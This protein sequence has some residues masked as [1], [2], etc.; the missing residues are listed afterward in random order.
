[1]SNIFNKKIEGMLIVYQFD[2][3]IEKHLE[4]INFKSNE[5]GGGG[6][7][8][9]GLCGNDSSGGESGSILPADDR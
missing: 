4:N 8:K 6:G 9:G 2:N 5:E 7:S 3:E 1:M